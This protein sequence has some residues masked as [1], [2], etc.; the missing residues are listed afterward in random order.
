MIDQLTTELEHKTKHINELETNITNLS[1]G[2]DSI[3]SELQNLMSQLKE[4]ES[5]KSK[6]E[7]E[8]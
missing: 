4:S 6:L 2:G 7:N 5:E 1:S 3:K 8:M